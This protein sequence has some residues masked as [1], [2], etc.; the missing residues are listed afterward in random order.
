M[1]RIVVIGAA[2]FLIPG[3]QRTAAIK[4]K[5][6]KPALASAVVLPFAL[7]VPGEVQDREFAR[8]LTHAVT[9]GLARLTRRSP[10]GC[11]AACV[12][13][14]LATDASAGAVAGRLSFLMSHLI[15]RYITGTGGRCRAGSG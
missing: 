6:A 7:E 13:A 12:A 3:S 11:N 14:G 10:R 2:A 9:A 15:S 5:S 4:T 1:A 8:Q